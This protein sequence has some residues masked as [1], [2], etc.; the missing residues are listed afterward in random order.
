MTVPN[1]PR[2]SRHILTFQVSLAYSL[3]AGLA[4]CLVFAFCILAYQPDESPFEPDHV[5]LRDKDV[6]NRRSRTNPVDWYLLFWRLRAPVHSGQSGSRF[7]LRDN[8]RVAQALTSVISPLHCML[9]ISDFQLVTGLSILISG[10]TQLQCGISKYHW[11][12][13]VQLAWFSSI[14]HLCCLTFLRDYFVR[15][16]LAQFW[17]IPGMV[18]LVLMLALALSPTALYTWD[19]N[20]AVMVHDLAAPAICSFFPHQLPNG[21]TDRAGVQR[22]AISISMLIAGM[23]L[24]LCRLYQSPTVMYLTIR[25]RCSAVSKRVLW[26]IFSSTGRDSFSSTAITILA[27]RPALAAF[28]CYRIL[29][30]L[31]S[32]KAFEVWWLALSFTWGILNLWHQERDIEPESREWSFGQVIALVLLVAPVCALIEGYCAVG[33]SNVPPEP[34]RSIVTLP[35]ERSALITT[36]PPRHAPE[37]LSTL[38]A[39]TRSPEYSPAHDFYGEPHFCTLVHVVLLTIAVTTG[40]TVKVFTTEHFVPLDAF[41]VWTPYTLSMSFVLC[42]SLALA[43]DQTTCK[44]WRAPRIIRIALGI[45]YW[46]TFQTSILA[47][48]TMRFLAFETW[49]RI[50][51]VAVYV[52]ASLLQLR[53]KTW[54]DV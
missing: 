21:F 53:W 20:G 46:V 41:L 5:T 14:T 47:G 54:R 27:Y 39:N 6:F 50:S 35:Q 31:A 29:F 22:M 44:M 52:S 51:L 12:K 19:Y 25:A 49:W 8:R 36:F 18:V 34:L 30:D 13:I 2:S 23:A 32:S 4:L 10:Y 1:H 15:N 7:S 26:A 37:T 33:T 9:V 11:Q 16:T 3:T 45:I 38:T 42:V 40:W 24:R 28:L 43:F 17:R 48:F